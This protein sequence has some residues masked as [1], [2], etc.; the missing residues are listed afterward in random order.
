MRVGAY[1]SACWA[2]CW[3]ALP[4][5]CIEAGSSTHILSPRRSYSPLV[6][7]LESMGAQMRRP[8]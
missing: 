3:A 8:A 2:A 5:N 4:P 7:W 6:P 1:G